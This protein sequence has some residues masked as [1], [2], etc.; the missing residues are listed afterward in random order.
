MPTFLPYKAQIKK[1]FSMASIKKTSL[2][3]GLLSAVTIE[4]EFSRNRDRIGCWD[5]IS[6]SG[7]SF[8]K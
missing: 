5:K 1:M 6:R 4:H 7:F 2:A 3:G 8:L